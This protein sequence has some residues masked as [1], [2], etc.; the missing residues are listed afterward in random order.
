MCVSAVHCMFNVTLL[1]DLQPESLTPFWDT[2]RQAA[3]LEDVFSMQLCGTAHSHNASAEPAMEGNLVSPR[4][5]FSLDV[6]TVFSG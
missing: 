6:T 4:A 3:D 1:S 5:S 2:L